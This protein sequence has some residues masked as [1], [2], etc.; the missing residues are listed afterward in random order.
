VV[1]Y[2]RVETQAAC[3]SIVFTATAPLEH[4]STAILE[5]SAIIFSSVEAIA[6]IVAGWS[7]ITLP[8]AYG[9]GMERYLA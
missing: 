9:P 4:F 3:T 2:V 1:Y 6:S 5:N 8:H 7:L